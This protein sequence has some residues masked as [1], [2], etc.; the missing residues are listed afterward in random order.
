MAGGTATAEAQDCSG[1]FESDTSTH[2]KLDKSVAGHI[3][4]CVVAC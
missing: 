3:A 4:H 2:S 1:G